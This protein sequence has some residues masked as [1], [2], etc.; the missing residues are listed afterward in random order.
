[1]VSVDAIVGAILRAKG[2]LAT[3][4]R[5]T[6]TG[7]MAVLDAHARFME[8]VENGNCYFASMQAGASLGTAL[9]ATAVTLTIY[10]PA[11]SG[12][13]LVIMEASVGITTGLA[14][15]GTSVLVYAVNNNLN[16]AAPTATTNAIITN[17]LLNN[18]T[19]KGK[20]FTAATL[21]AVPTVA[22]I[23]WSNR[24][25][26]ATP[27]TEIAGVYVDQVDGKIIIPQGACLT[28]QGIGTAISGILSVMWEEVAV[29]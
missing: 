27:V 28:I 22:K 12:V 26:G 9:T 2:A 5:L 20:A 15:A 19:G 6:K 29:V 8:A 1:M 7:A 18:L 17:A 10:N 11:G 4:F 14:A 24:L 21:S 23:L 13:N 16:A 3:S 25:I